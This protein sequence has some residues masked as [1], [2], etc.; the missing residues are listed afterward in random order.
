MNPEEETDKRGGVESKKLLVWKRHD[1]DGWY[2]RG[3]VQVA[4]PYRVASPEREERFGGKASV[5]SLLCN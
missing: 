5:A 2:V 1:C 4:F 3:P